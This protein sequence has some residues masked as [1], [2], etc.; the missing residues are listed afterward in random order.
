MGKQNVQAE[1]V[2]CLLSAGRRFCPAIVRASISGD[3]FSFPVNRIE[4]ENG[5]NPVF[6]CLHGINNNSELYLH[7]SLTIQ[8]CRSVESVI[9]VVI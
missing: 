5:L 2:Y 9:T 1:K 8:Y 4:C 7:V 6:S 3:T